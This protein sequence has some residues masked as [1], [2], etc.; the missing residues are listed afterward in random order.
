MIVNSLS[1][2][3]ASDLESPELTN[4]LSFNS[5]ISFHLHNYNSILYLIV[6]HIPHDTI[7]LTVSRMFYWLR[8]FSLWRFLFR[9]S[10]TYHTVCICF[11]KF[12][13]YTE[14][15]WVLLFLLAIFTFFVRADRVMVSV[16]CWLCS[17]PASLCSGHLKSLQS[18]SSRSTLPLPLIAIFIPL[19]KFII[20][21]HMMFILLRHIYVLL[22]W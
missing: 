15:S 6:S 5:P 13:Y 16:P 21:S 12:F 20:I 4:S 8:N 18:G 17:I 11:W 19:K 14:G 1:S 2:N 7:L 22:F 3:S 10:Y 9:L